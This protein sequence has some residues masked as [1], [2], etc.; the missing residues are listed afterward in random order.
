MVKVKR[1]KK[2]RRSHRIDEED[3]VLNEED[4]DLML[5]NTGGSSR[6]HQVCIRLSLQ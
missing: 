3:E 5:G 1:R 6:D 4:L 2:R